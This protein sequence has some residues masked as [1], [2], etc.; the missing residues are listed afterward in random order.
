MITFGDFEKIDMSV[1][2]IVKAKLFK[3]SKEARI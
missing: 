2:E 3:K 1:E